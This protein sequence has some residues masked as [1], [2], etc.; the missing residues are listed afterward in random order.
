MIAVY[1]PPPKTKMVAISPS[2]FIIRRKSVQKVAVR[3]PPCCLLT[4]HVSFPQ[5]LTRLVQAHALSPSCANPGFLLRRGDEPIAA[6]FSFWAFFFF[7]EAAKEL[8]GPFTTAPDFWGTDY[9][10]LEWDA[11][12]NRSRIVFCA[13]VFSERRGLLSPNVV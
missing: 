13:K 11:R 3:V 8:N 5:P 6:C 1:R 9:W 4:G 2:G 12:C 7:S 10:N